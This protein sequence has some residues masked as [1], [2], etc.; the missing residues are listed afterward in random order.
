MEELFQEFV[1]DP[2]LRKVT[3]AMK[4]SND[5]FNIID[6]N[7][8]QHSDIL[9]W[10]FD[11]REGHGQGDA[12]LKDFLTAAYGN[13]Y[14]N[15]LSNKEF[16]AEWTPSRIAR[17]GFHSMISIREY[18]LPSKRRLDL[19]MIDTVNKILVVVENKYGAKLGETQ[20]AGYYEEVSTLR[21]R[22][23]F[24]GYKTAFVVLDRHYGGAKDE[25][26]N[27]TAPRNR[28]A[29]IDYQWLEAG[30]DRA[31]LQLRRG[32]QSAGLVI[33]YC[34]KQTD[35]VPP[36]E[37]EFD[38]ILA[39]VARDYRPVLKALAD[40]QSHEIGELTKGNLSGHIGELWI[41]AN[42]H[43]DLVERLR[44]K[45]ELSH[46]ESRLRSNLPHRKLDMDYG[47]NSFWLFN[48]NWYCFSDDNAKS[49]PICVHGWEMRRV[50]RGEGKFA[51]GIQFRPFNLSEEFRPQV[52]EAL[53]T[54]FPELKRGRQNAA[55][56]MLG[57]TA[58]I[59]EPAL[60]AKAQSVYERLEQALAPLVVPLD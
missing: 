21:G 14:D 45:A 32:N 28:W 37:K 33:A 34:Q 5:I 17:T 23:A 19:L 48:E 26:E 31:E 44:S 27:R 47:K 30:A 2:R 12:I 13:S 51:V 53:E 41:F 46:I 50:A 4:R 20:L 39:D 9:K 36:E 18:C 1:S 11:P 60:A 24:N 3:E 59:S 55:F 29:F 57:K 56:R 6:P 54:A 35:Y 25:N 10:L 8:N 22:P 7:E 42:H 52:Q 49:W 38:D 15:V 58:E 40:A 16:F 43:P